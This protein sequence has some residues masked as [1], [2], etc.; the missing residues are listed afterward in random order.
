MFNNVTSWL[1]EFGGL[2][3]QALTTR[4]CTIV[5]EGRNSWTFDLT[6]RVLVWSSEGSVSLRQHGK[7]GAVETA[8]GVPTYCSVSK[9]FL[10]EKDK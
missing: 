10:L 6:F 2:Y 7:G 3:V 8:A 9:S 1:K 5:Y 4:P